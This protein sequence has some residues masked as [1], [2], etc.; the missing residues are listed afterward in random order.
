MR[1]VIMF[2]EAGMRHAQK[3]EYTAALEALE[4]AKCCSDC[5]RK[6]TRELQGIINQIERERF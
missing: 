3:H 2:V 1:L 6:L 5:S 4:N